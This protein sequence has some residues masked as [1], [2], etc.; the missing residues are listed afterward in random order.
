MD[1]G[2]GRRKGLGLGLGLGYPPEIERGKEG[3]NRQQN[4]PPDTE[5]EEVAVEKARQT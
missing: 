4:I 2:K 5:S 3:A 1:H